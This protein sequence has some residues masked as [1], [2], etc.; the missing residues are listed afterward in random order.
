MGFDD[1]PTR[2]GNHDIQTIAEVAFNSAISNAEKFVVQQVDRQDY[3]TDFQI[4]ARDG[5][6][7]TNFRVHVQVKGTEKELN[8]SGAL[9]ISVERQNLNYLLSQPLS[10]YVAYHPVSY[11]H[12]TLP[13]I[14]SV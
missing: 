11:T 14:C 2:H 7:M 12:L 10:L 5:D 13:T 1:L 8:K 9:S 4:E 6:A 3:G